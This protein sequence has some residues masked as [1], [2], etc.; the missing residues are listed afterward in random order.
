MNIEDIFNKKDTNSVGCSFSSFI[1][2]RMDECLRVL[3]KEDES[4]LKCFHKYRD[5][6]LKLEDLK[7]KGDDKNLIKEYL[8]ASF[9]LT[10]AEQ[11]AIYKQGFS[12]AILLMQSLGL[13]KG[14]F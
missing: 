11:P 14:K 10:A 7:L 5:L 13:L 4:Y 2:S 8:S 9:S 6:L 12:D 1:D 3:K